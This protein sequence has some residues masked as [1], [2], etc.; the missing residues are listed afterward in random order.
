MFFITKLFR[1]KFFRA[2]YLAWFSLALF[3]FY[4]YI[5]R[6]APG[7]MIEEL[8][9]AFKINAQEFATFGSFYLIAYGVLQIPLGVI[10]DR[11]GVRTM[12]LYSVLICIFASVPCM[13]RL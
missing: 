5:L 3:F 7:V 11:V 13:S 9:A 10:V 8:R 12:A 1:N 6:V 2:S 4:Q